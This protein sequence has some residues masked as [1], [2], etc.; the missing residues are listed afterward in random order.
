VFLNNPPPDG[1]TT[2][3]GEFG[4]ATINPLPLLLAWASLLRQSRLTPRSVLDCYSRLRQGRSWGN[5]IPLYVMHYLTGTRFCRSHVFDRGAVRSSR[6]HTTTQDS[7]AIV[8]HLLPCRRPQSIWLVGLL[9][10]NRALHSGGSGAGS[11][12]RKA[13]SD[14]ITGAAGGLARPA[15]LLRGPC[16]CSS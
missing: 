10:R 15:W 2:T 12:P 13:M 8:S 6:R 16:S 1:R 14:P 9:Q 11:N 3:S 7:R 5:P 4:P